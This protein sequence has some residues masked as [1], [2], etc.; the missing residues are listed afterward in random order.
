MRETAAILVAGGIVPHPGPGADRV[1]ALSFVHPAVSNRT[2]VR[3]ASEAI[4]P[5]VI[6]EMDVL[7]F[8][9]VGNVEGVGYQRQRALGFPGW[10]LV[11]DPARAML[12]LDVMR[13]F[14][15][16]KKR[17]VSKPGHA[18]DGFQAIADDLGGK[19]PHFLPSFW[20]EVGRGYIEAGNPAMA[21]TA[22]DKARNVERQHGLAV[23]D[24]RLSDVYL[25]F[26]LAGA[27]TVRSLQ[28]YAKE[29]Q[30]LHG[31]KAGYERFF[32]LCVGRTLGG[33]SL[34]STA[35]KDLRSAARA[36]GLDPDHEDARFLRAVLGSSGFARA[37]FELLRGYEAAIQQVATDPA[38]RAKL[39]DLWPKCATAADRAGWLSIL[40]RAG[41]FEAFERPKGELPEP[42]GGVAA[43]V[44]KALAARPLLV[45]E[46]LPLVRRFAPRLRTDG[47]AVDMVA[48]GFQIPGLDVVDLLIELGVP[49][50]AAPTNPWVMFDLRAGVGSEPRDVV[51][52]AAHPVIGPILR[53]TVARV[54]HEPWFQ[55]Y[56]RGKVA[57]TA[58]R[59]D[60]L[61]RQIDRLDGTVH[62]AD[63]LLTALP[64]VASPALWA[65]FPEALGRLRAWDPAAS[66]RRS[67]VGG[68]FAELRWPALEDVIRETGRALAVHTLHPYAVLTDG[69]RA[70]VLDVDRPEARLLVH[71]LRLP[72][73]SYLRGFAYAQGQLFVA[74]VAQGFRSYWSGGL[75]EINTELTWSISQ[76]RGVAVLPDGRINEGGRAYGAGDGVQIVGRPLWDGTHVWRADVKAR[77]TAIDPV[78][79]AP[80][81]LAVPPF[82]GR[83]GY[84]DYHPAS[85]ESP[86]GVDGG[87]YG[88]STR[89]EAGEPDIPGDYPSVRVETLSGRSVRTRSPI[90]AFVR[91]PGD[92][93]P[94]LCFDTTHVAEPALQGTGW[95]S[96]A[97]FAADDPLGAT[98]RLLPPYLWHALRPR[99]EAASRI[100]RGVSLE[101]ARVL[102]DAA[103]AAPEHADWPALVAR[104]L[105]ITDPVILRDVGALCKV[106]L[107]RIERHGSV[108]ALPAAARAQPP[109]F[110]VTEEQ[111]KPALS[112]LL[113]LRYGEGDLGGAIDGLIAAF[114]GVEDRIP[115]SRF[116]TF[117]WPGRLGGLAFLA[118]CPAVPKSAR[119]ATLRLLDHIATSPLCTEARNIR[120]VRLAV[121]QDC[122]LILRPQKTPRLSEAWSATIDGRHYACQATW[123]QGTGTVDA[124]ELAKNARF[125]LPAGATLLATSAPGAHPSGDWLRRFVVLAQARGAIP[126]GSAIYEA[127]SAGTGLT[128][129]EA[130]LVWA[131]MPYI[132]AFESDFLG[133][134]RREELDL[135]VAD[136][137]AARAT[138]VAIPVARRLELYATAIPDDPAD[139]WN[140]LDRVVP[141]LCVV[142]NEM[143]GR[144]AS[145][146]EELFAQ[147]RVDLVVQDGPAFLVAL[148]DVGSS[149]KFNRD[150]RW[151]M[152]ARGPV[153]TEAGDGFSASSLRAAAV[154]VPW[155]NAYTPV[156]AALRSNLRVLREKLDERLANPDLLLPVGATYGETPNIRA[157]LHSI[158][159]PE[160]GSLVETEGLVV[161]SAMQSL[162]ISVR[163]ARLADAREILKRLPQL[164]EWPLPK[165][166]DCLRLLASPGYRAI[167]DRIASS[168][169]PVGS[170]EQDPRLS[171]AHTVAAVQAALKLDLPAATLYLQVLSLHDPTRKNVLA[172]NGWKPAD[173]AR[174]EAVLLGRELLV[175]GKRPRAGR[176]VFLPGGWIERSKGSL[177]IERWKLPLFEG[178][179]DGFPLDAALPLCPIHQLFERAWARVTRDDAPRY[180]EAG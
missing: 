151:K 165:V 9:F 162:A 106:L 100:L 177:P 108:C 119:E 26:S 170:W 167:L 11:H 3:L 37:T 72:P 16:H 95:Q 127:I 107:L 109:R 130:A 42:S 7:G 82:L 27:L 150:L 88:F 90:R 134:E 62:A 53:R 47:V 115:I 143:F 139:F 175:G 96:I 85:N 164:H 4:A 49:C 152:E 145:V 1:S 39:L 21:A 153:P 113:P 29:L 20:E 8:S 160:G 132:D 179:A 64:Q 56:A 176:D 142:W 44:A 74:L 112:A 93:T 78:S 43:W 80:I 87:Q 114:Q 128:R 68:L 30:K 120:R 166:T 60:W 180:E 76:P 66:L 99:D 45:S 104:H 122:R 15:V 24:G 103:I 61:N 71:D 22:F 33:V 111:V 126:G 97:P 157:F 110:A 86:L 91:L 101:R 155:V 2:V 25:E 131:G 149:P 31:P 77:L 92:E 140:P 5:G 48:T 52:A 35:Q 10:A 163:P 173:Y 46:L 17:I 125:G 18:K 28:T 174:A 129:T 73:G 102:L 19:V 54:M 79:G 169:V 123:Q 124:L 41:C 137:K 51:S 89:N 94:R 81:P 83:A 58:L 147:A 133:K 57:Y 156:G 32:E 178:S 34:W 144:R 50:G 161:A 12:A 23:D 121:T 116:A 70:W 55:E 117:D 136:V 65:E 135:K 36:A 67:L 158:G 159:F 14:K 118:V 84:V 75:D 146:P 148:A 168:P 63:G 13:Q 171:A 98:M 6:A 38:M 59:R 105:P 138:L 69:R 154:L 40:D 141:R 172:W